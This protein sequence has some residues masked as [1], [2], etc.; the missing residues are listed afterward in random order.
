MR[1]SIFGPALALAAALA[2]VACSLPSGS[3]SATSPPA[4]AV[5]PPTGSTAISAVAQ[6][7]LYAAETA[8]NVPAQAYV[9]LDA[10]GALPADLKA[11]AKPVLLAAYSAL[12][13][14]RKA[15][16]LGDS[17]GVIANAKTAQAQADTAA[18]ILPPP[19]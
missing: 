17:A 3:E 1:I 14:A 18:A 9:A 5:A 4:P 15:A 2:L 10:R 16:K 19:T 8:Y 7:A 11:R 13:A 6:K 12:L